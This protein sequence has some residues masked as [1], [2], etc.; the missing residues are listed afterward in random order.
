MKQAGFAIIELLI[1]IIVIVI[2]ATITTVVFRG[3]Q[4]RAK[5][6]AI[7]STEGQYK[8]KLELYKVENG[9]YP[10]DQASFDTL[11]GQKSTDKFY[12][13]YTFNCFI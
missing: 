3:A 7:A 12:T 1:V 8:K 4:Q 2:L 6:S 11:T 9:S 10:S 5:E 13:T